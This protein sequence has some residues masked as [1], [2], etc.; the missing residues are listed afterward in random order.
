[1]RSCRCRGERVAVALADP[2]SS[3]AGFSRRDHRAA[4]SSAAI[5]AIM[6]GG[7][8]PP[9]LAALP[10]R[11]PKH[12]ASRCSIFLR[13][14]NARGWR[15]ASRAP[16]PARCSKDFCD[17]FRLPGREGEPIPAAVLVPIINRPEGLQLLLT[18]R[19]AICPTIRGRS[20]FPAAA[21]DPGGCRAAPPR[22]AKPTRSG[23]PAA[24]VA[25]SASSSPTKPSAAFACCRSWG[26]SIR[27]SARARSG[28]SRRHL[29]GAARLHP[30]SRRTI[31]GTFRMLGDVAATTGRFPGCERFIWGATAAMLMIFER[32]LSAAD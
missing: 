3:E 25:F 26:G 29:R 22:C 11:W 14:C 19:S 4:M 12:P 17:G 32:T 7:N 6:F 16:C 24:K 13:S 31:S 23:A 10:N 28:G 21:L 20:V 18:Q 2:D 15:S 9:Y 8:V 5:G 30:R 27:R 1:M